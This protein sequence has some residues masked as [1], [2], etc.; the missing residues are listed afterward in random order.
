MNHTLA[1]PMELINHTF[2][3][4]DYRDLLSCTQVDCKF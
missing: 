2:Y 4:L 3:Y 1:L